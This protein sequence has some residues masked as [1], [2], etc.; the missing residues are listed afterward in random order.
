[1]KQSLL[2][3][4]LRKEMVGLARVTVLVLTAFLFLLEFGYRAD[5]ATGL[6]LDQLSY[7]LVLG[8]VMVALGSG[9]RAKLRDEPVRNAEFIWFVLGIGLL[10][11]R[12]F[13]ME[14]WPKAQHWPHLLYLLGFFFI[15]LSRLEL[16]RN[17]TLFNPAL[18]FTVSFVMLIAI[19]AALFL[20][21]N[22]GTR[23]ITL[24]EALFTSTSAVC[25]TGLSV[26]DVGKDLTLLGQ[27]VLLLLI[28]LGGLGVM[29]FTSFFAFFFKG[30]YKPGGT[31][32]HQGHRQYFPG[33]RQIIHRTGHPVHLGRGTRRRCIDLLRGASRRLPLDRRPDVLRRV[34]FHLSLQQ[35]RL[36]HP[37]LGHV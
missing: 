1:M 7:G 8:A 21:P 25:V 32:S 22:T 11:L 31:T 6:L 26:I 2:R 19:G 30:S 20:L 23:P 37:K 16:G 17:S 4:V 3:T 13:D 33:E 18:L 34:P 28:Q 15:E 24:V 35:C 9:L 36:L 10:L 27:W 14:F 29:T 12:P 5:A